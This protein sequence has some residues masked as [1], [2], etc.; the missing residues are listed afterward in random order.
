MMVV[1]CRRS[2]AQYAFMALLVKLLIGRLDSQLAPLRLAGNQPRSALGKK[3]V[4]PVGGQL[5]FGRRD[6]REL[7][8]EEPA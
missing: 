2:A 8:G 5:G 4:W 3:R 6:Y 1:P 7:A